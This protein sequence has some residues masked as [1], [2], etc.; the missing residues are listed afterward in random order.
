[1]NKIER[2]QL[3]SCGSGKKYKNCCGKT[4]SLALFRKKILE[5]EIHQIKNKLFT[6]FI[7]NWS[8]EIPGILV[9]F[10]GDSIK[11]VPELE[12]R[13][14]NMVVEFLD[15][16]ENADLLLLIECVLFDYFTPEGETFFQKFLK[17]EKKNLRN[18][19]VEVLSQWGDSYISIYEVEEICY[20]EKIIILK[21]ILLNT[22]SKVNLMEIPITEIEVGNLFIARLLSKGE[23]YETLG[24]ILLSGILKQELID[25]ITELKNQKIIGVQDNDWRKF[26]KKYGYEVI[27]SIAILDNQY[28]FFGGAIEDQF[29]WINDKQKEV[30]RLIRIN[31]IEDYPN[32]DVVI[33]I[34]LWYRYCELKKPKINKV[35][36]II[37][38]IEYVIALKL[39]R[40]V[41]QK[42]IALKYGV[43][44]NSISSRY[45]EFMEI[46][47]GCA[48]DPV[49][50]R[51]SLERNLLAISKSLK[52]IW[53]DD[54]A[55][56]NQLINE[57]FGKINSF[58]KANI[59]LRDKAQNL[60]YDAWETTG[61][62][63]VELAKKALEIYP[64]S[65]DAYVIL[66]QETATTFEE[67]LY[68]YRKGVEAGERVFGKR[69]FE[70]NKGHFWGL[71]ETR[72]Y[73][74]AK[75]GLA[76]TFEFL[77]Y[78]NEAIKHYKEMLELNPNDNQG[79]R[80]NLLTL[81]L[82]ENRFTEAKNLLEKY[83]NDISAEFKYNKCVLEYK[84]SGASNITKKLFKE[85]IAYNPFVPD[86]L[87][88]VKQLPLF[89]P[90]YISP[91]GED[92]AIYYVTK[93]L[94]L[95]LETPNLFELLEKI[96]K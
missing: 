87:L 80:Y 88:G 70:E 81:L 38:A 4:E 14:K 59:S 23:V 25:R 27:I 46:V 6:N 37:A 48:V 77:N 24:F 10:L 43:S 13:I 12:K 94:H 50:Q 19:V 84:L 66:A 83:N 89:P 86:Y 32:E 31:L 51:I 63:R 20:E 71:I 54:P 90:L 73:M 93:N 35:E 75:L 42:E 17:N 62:K 22:R 60:L 78:K 16:N 96:V 5:R 95:W 2:N 74:R 47:E 67:A 49:G 53:I 1:M 72:P 40:F 61:K 52:K 30:A 11:E 9:E 65:P 36:T 92:E 39:G 55:E 91:G 85:A 76:E 8:N 68:L 3:C 58:A 79:V 82:E 26:L 33:A 45:K 56:I 7:F 44:P 57:N 21:D 28:D 69:Y 29:D 18:L 34:A 15:E 41:T 64:D